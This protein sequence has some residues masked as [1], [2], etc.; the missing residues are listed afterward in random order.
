[1]Y[2]CEKHKSGQYYNIDPETNR[3][4]IFNN[5]TDI[6]KFMNHTLFKK[7]N[8]LEEDKYFYGKQNYI[9]NIKMFKIIIS[10]FDADTITELTPLACVGTPPEQPII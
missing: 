1:M 3:N 2:I 6:K 5:D 7:P 4:K 8:L 9:D 10:K